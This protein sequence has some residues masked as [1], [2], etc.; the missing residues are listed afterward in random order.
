MMMR[1]I[2]VHDLPE[3]L[4]RDIEAIAENIRAR[5]AA[6]EEP[7]DDLSIVA[8]L[9]ILEARG[10][11]MHDSRGRIVHMPDAGR[12]RLIANVGS[13]G[14]ESHSPELPLWPGVAPSLEAMSRE[15]IY[16]DVG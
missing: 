13:N 2:D 10:W 8:I 16:R 3:T 7:R 5:L 4:A 14:D 11:R 1:T 15:E 9:S 6:G 12:T